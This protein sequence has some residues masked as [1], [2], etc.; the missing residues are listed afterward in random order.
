MR[1]DIVLVQ[2]KVGKWD[3]LATRLPESLLAIAAIPDQKGYHVK[4][5]D[6]RTEEDWERQLLSSLKDKPICVGT[7]TMTGKQIHY[8]L[9]VSELVKKHSEAPVVWGGIHPT[10]LPKQTLENENVDILVMREGELTFIDLVKT[11]EKGK[12][13]K[14]V[15]GIYY[16]E[17]GKIKKTSPRPFIK[18]L[19][20]LPLLPYHLL[21]LKKYSTFDLRDKHALTFLTSRGCPFR[22][23]FCHNAVTN[24]RIWRGFSAEETV[25]RLKYMVDEFGIRDFFIEDDNFCG[26]MKRFR[27]IIDLLVKEDMDIFWGSLGVRADAIASMDRKL[28]KKMV[29]SGCRNLDVGA[30]SGSQR[31]LDLCQK[32]TTV[33]EIKAV[34]RKIAEYPIIMK[35]T[36]IVGF[37]TETD[38]EIKQSIDLA[39]ELVK[40]NKKVYTPFF[41]YT[42]YPGTKMYKFAIDHGLVPPKSLEKWSDFDFENWFWKYPS[43]LDKRRIKMLSNLYHT[44]MLYNKNIKYKITSRYLRWLFDLYRPF[45]KIRFENNFYHFQIERR[46]EDLVFRLFSQ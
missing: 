1:K 3:A 13:L 27:E 42:P 30:E 20:S 21:D 45:A 41:I 33:E 25:R 32:D 35:Y 18:D 8:A 43:W 34:N 24:K 38:G 31:I 23:G 5:I 37:P 9:Q 22:C 7:S 17:N 16:K 28:L 14:S 19:D 39:L 11:L 40:D 12:S 44:S 46:L 36:F 10:L 29:K 26:N 4:I 15:K 6:Q 2:P